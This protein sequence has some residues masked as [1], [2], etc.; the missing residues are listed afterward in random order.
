MTGAT[1]QRKAFHELIARHQDILLT[2]HVNPDGDGLGSEVATAL[3]LGPLGKSV[4]ILNDSPVPPAFRF[5]AEWHPI[6]TFD[7]DV[8]EARFSK[9]TL[10]VVLDTSNVQRIGRLGP[11]IDRH[12]IEVA[13]VD[14][15]VSHNGF[16][17]VNVIEPA[18]AA[19]GEIV[20]DL[21]REAS[22]TFT[23]E[24][25][26]ALYVALMTDTGSFRYS[27]SDSAAHR[28]AAELLAHGL[29]PQPIHS[30]VY[31]NATAGRLRFF[32]EVLGAMEIAAEGRL[33]VLEA[34]PEQFRKHGLVGA[35]TE[36]LVDM[37]RMI[38]GLE[39]V[40]LFSEVER[41]KVKVSLRSTGR[42]AIDAVCTRFGGGGH[43]HAAGVMMS[44]S[45][46]DAKTRILPQ[47][48]KLIDELDSTPAG[49]GA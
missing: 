20:Y 24:I 38:G 23:P 33:A 36:G 8:A 44:G 48:R 5:L 32:G 6:D 16:G 7:E 49:R 11:F 39:A 29:D 31:S 10:L 22:A 17:K 26:E 25:A 18:A 9:A 30:K 35:D 40:A 42:V 3:W 47:I 13:I 2:T 27:N 43:P 37:P 41:G 28:M 19:T 34:A 45:R 14:H 4:D 21:M 15:H 46:E 1:A 12:A